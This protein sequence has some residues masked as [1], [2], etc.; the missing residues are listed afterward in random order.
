MRHV[1][2]YM[3]RNIEDGT[4]IYYYQNKGSPWMKTYGEAENWLSKMEAV[5]LDVDSV[6][7]PNTKWIFEGTLMLM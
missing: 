6:E 2:S 5:R 7:R 1:Y 4:I 3:L